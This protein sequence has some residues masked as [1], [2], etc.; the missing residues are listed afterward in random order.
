MRV[1]LCGC[2]GSGVALVRPARL[3]MPPVRAQWQP[4]PIWMFRRWGQI[5]RA[6][7]Y[8]HP[9]TPLAVDR[10]RRRDHLRGA[11]KMV[12]PRQISNA[13]CPEA[14]TGVRV[15]CVPRRSVGRL[16]IE[17]AAVRAVTG[18]LGVLSLIETD[19]VTARVSILWTPTPSA[20]GVRRTDLTRHRSDFEYSEGSRLKRGPSRPP[21]RSDLK[22]EM[23]HWE[24]RARWS[25][26]SILDLTLPSA[27]KS[28]GRTFS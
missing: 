21:G 17:V 13:S 10:P 8:S 24:P 22:S 18:H 5:I 12:Q 25:R 19:P 7:G 15:S 14:A 23:A 1:R 16:P 27:L 3:T 9:C 28:P 26:G 4:H 11:T 6:Q 20:G 2:S